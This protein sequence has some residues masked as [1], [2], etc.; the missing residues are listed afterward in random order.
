MA[1][2]WKNPRWRIG[3]K[4]GVFRLGIRGKRSVNFQFSLGSFLFLAVAIGFY[5][6]AFWCCCRFWFL[7]ETLIFLKPREIFRESFIVYVGLFG[8]PVMEEGDFLVERSLSGGDHGLGA[9]PFPL[10]SLDFPTVPKKHPKA[11]AK[12]AGQAPHT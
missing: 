10:F 2:R 12:M 9:G 3:G 6:V 5:V 11:I 8:N 4:G 7:D 1:S